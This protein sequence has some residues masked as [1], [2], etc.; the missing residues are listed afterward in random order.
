MDNRDISMKKV[1]GTN[2]KMKMNM[3]NTNN[4]KQNKNRNTLLT[5]KNRK[6]LK[7]NKNK[8]TLLINKK[9]MGFLPKTANKITKSQHMN[10]S[11]KWKTRIGNNKKS[12]K[13]NSSSQ[14]KNG[15]KI[16]KFNNRKIPLCKIRLWKSIQ[17]HRRQEID[18][19]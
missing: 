3:H 17:D 16:K 8:D 14:N 11:F 12:N 15:N 2:N 5:N 19:Y 9:K 1:K 18:F 10:S 7:V 4:N 6:T 13:C